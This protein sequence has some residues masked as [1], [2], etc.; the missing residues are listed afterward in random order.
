MEGMDSNEVTSL[1]WNLGASLFLLIADN[2][3]GAVTIGFCSN[4]PS[5]LCVDWTV[6]ASSHIEVRCPDGS[7][8]SGWGTDPGGDPSGIVDPGGGFGG[9][10]NEQPE[11]SPAPGNP[12]SPTLMQRWGAARATALDKLEEDIEMIGGK[13][14]A[15]PNKCSLLFRNNNLGRKG[16]DLLNSYVIARGGEIIQ[17]PDGSVPCNSSS[18]SVWTTCC[19]HSPYVFVCN[20]F[21]NLPVSGRE[22]MA[23]HETLHV[24]G[25]GEDGSSSAGP[26]DSPTSGQIT[27]FVEEACDL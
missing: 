3:Q 26:G 2:A 19:N 23:I 4:Q 9:S 22:A 11:S 18:T 20:R 6:G 13:P 14:K 27:D 24:A 17:A 21:G 5:C 7:G 10:G 16:D 15:I 8:S 12:L 25:Q 1:A